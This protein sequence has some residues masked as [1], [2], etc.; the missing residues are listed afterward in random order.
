MFFC[1]YT[2]LRDFGIGLG[3]ALPG[4]YGHRCG[5]N[6]SE[7]TDVTDESSQHGE[8]P[9]NFEKIFADDWVAITPIFS[10]CDNMHGNARTNEK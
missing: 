1:R 7:E 8:A 3:F 9:V 4:L 10:I 6:Q 2:G 5:K